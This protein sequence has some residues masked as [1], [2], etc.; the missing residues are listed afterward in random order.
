[1]IACICCVATMVTSV[2]AA[3]ND[4]TDLERTVK[5]VFLFKFLNYADWPPTAFTDANAPYVIGIYGADAMA[6]DLAQLAEGRTVSG[7]SVE[8]RRLRRTD[9][10]AGVHVLFVGAADAAQLPALARAALR[11]PLLVV[12]EGEGA[13]DAG[14]A[15][16][17][18]VVDGRVRFD[19]ALDAADKSGVHLSSRL[20]SVARTVR[21]R[22]EP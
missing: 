6:S 16:S 19:V 5:A 13:L 17:L 7:R 3:V 18:L 10:L 21:N 4:E 12:S 22:S 1:M 11:Q 14:S 2:G 20:L 8:V 9:S 15:I